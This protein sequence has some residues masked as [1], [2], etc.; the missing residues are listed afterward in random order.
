MEKERPPENIAGMNAKELADKV[1]SSN[2]F[3]QERFFEELVKRYKKEAE[4]DYQRPSLTKPE[5]KRVQLASAL[6]RMSYAV[7]NSLLKPIHDICN[8][9]KKYL[10]NPYKK[11]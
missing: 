5:Q 1:V 8:A 2:F 3:Y 7:Q 6:E 10:H 11:D 4:E 9:S